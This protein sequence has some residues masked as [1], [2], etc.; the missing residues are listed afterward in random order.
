MARQREEGF[1]P[2]R[3]RSSKKERRGPLNCFPKKTQKAFFF[4][5]R[6]SFFLHC[7]KR[8]GPPSL[9]EQ[10]GNSASIVCGVL[11]FFFGMKLS[12]GK[13]LGHRMVE[14]FL[15]VLHRPWKH[16]VSFPKKIKKNLRFSCTKFRTD[17]ATKLAFSMRECSNLHI[18]LE[19]HF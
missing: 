1:L 16:V 12:R 17:E 9:F 7:N 13:S 10:R 5:W 18:T 15:S 3:I 6:F 8:E 2:P 4:L 11:L 19:R 14:G